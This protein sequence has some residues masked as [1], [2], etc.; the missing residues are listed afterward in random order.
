MQHPILSFDSEMIE[1]GLAVSAVM[2]LD[3]TND[4]CSHFH[5]EDLVPDDAL[6]QC[7]ASHKSK[8]S[9]VGIG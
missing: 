8:L 3:K 4:L 1:C 5:H 9:S 2:I 7:R 6:S